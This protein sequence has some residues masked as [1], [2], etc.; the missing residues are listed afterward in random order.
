MTD[1]KSIAIILWIND[2]EVGM[3]QEKYLSALHIPEGYTVE[4]VEVTEAQFR[5]EAYEKGRRQTNA[6][7]KVYLDVKTIMINEDILEDMLGVFKGD[8]SIGML[9]LI[10][11]EK[12]PTQGVCAW[13]NKRIGKA[14]D[15]HGKKFEK[16]IFET[17]Y[18]EVMAVDGF[19][20]MT[21]YDLP[22]RIDLFKTE[23]FWDT[24]QCIEYRK[25]GYK[26]VVPN[27]KDF[28][29][30]AD[31]AERKKYDKAS[32]EIFLDTYSKDIYPLVSVIIPT[33]N[34]PEYFKEALDSVIAQT[35][36]NIEI[37]ITDNSHNAK[38]KELMKPYLKKYDYIRYEHHPDFDAAGNWGVA[39]KYNN[40]EAPYVNWLMD[41]DLFVPDKIA[42]MV[43]CY[44]QDDGIALVT[45]YRELIG[46]RGEPICD[47]NWER[48][49]NE[50][51]R[52]DGE[53]MGRELFRLGRNFIGEPTTVLIKKEYMLN[54][55]ELGFSGEEGKYLISD[56]PT[57]LHCLQH[58]DMIYIYEPLSKFR[59]HAGQQQR[60]PETML[61]GT[62]CMGME[63]EYAWRHKIYLK[64]KKD[65][66]MAVLQWLRQMDYVIKEIR[67]LNYDSEDVAV[68]K[69][70]G[71]KL[72]ELSAQ[73]G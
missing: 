54:Q 56:F 41:D 62:I 38:T 34:R 59:M 24:A 51:T 67:K 15:K 14:I 21:Q 27:Q 20:I 16:W 68:I 36:R 53:A 71:A 47:P 65:F 6:K 4:L 46:P 33:Y 58:G 63:I 64:S 17:D 9:G 66:E 72:L 31:W 8:L 69:K 3:K 18:K 40:P 70:Q 23:A 10:G 57:W 49:F 39:Q 26:V 48:A 50:T 61:S 43:D 55:R 37:F 11:T 73:S 52:A 30:I 60:S 35:Y 7:Y 44:E 1:E 5:T 12:I 42:Q 13:A 29:C 28:W 19:L 45:S 22:W 2:E 25:A 32:Q